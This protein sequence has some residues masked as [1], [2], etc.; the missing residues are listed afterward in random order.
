MWVSTKYS[1]FLVCFIPVVIYTNYQDPWKPA[2]FLLFYVIY[3]IS[4]VDLAW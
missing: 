2:G 1:E 3:F 4:I